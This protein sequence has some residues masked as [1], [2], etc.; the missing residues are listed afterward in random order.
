MD[1]P[2][3]MK[4]AA[5]VR[6]PLPSLTP[7]LQEAFL[8]AT[9]EGVP[10]ELAGARWAAYKAFHQSGLFPTLALPVR[11]VNLGLESGIGREP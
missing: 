10:S 1:R 9:Q 5:I 6:L 11:I 7:E 3:S 4:P 8:A 2:P